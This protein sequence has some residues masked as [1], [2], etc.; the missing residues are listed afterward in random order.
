M[1]SRSI[2]FT[3]NALDH[4]PPPNYPNSIL[5]LSLKR[6]VSPKELNGKVYPI[7]PTTPGI[8]E[9]RCYP[10]NVDGTPPHQLKFNELDSS[11]SD[12]ELRESAFHPLAFEDET[13]CILTSAICHAASDGMGV[14]SV[15][16]IW[17][18]NCRDVQL[19]KVPQMKQPPERGE[20]A[21]KQKAN[22]LQKAINAYV[23]YISP[24]N[25]IALREECMKELGATQVSVNDV[26]CALV[27]RCLL[28][29]RTAARESS[30]AKAQ[31]L[32]PNYLGNFTIINQTLLP[33]P[34]LVAPSRIAGEV[35]PANLM[36]AYVLVKTVRTSL[37]LENLKVD[38]NG[39]MITSL[40]AFPLVEICFGETIFGDCGKPK[41][42]RTLMGAINQTFRYSVILPRKDYR[43]VEVVANL[44]QGEMDILM[45]DE[46]FLKYV[47][48]VA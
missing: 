21:P 42:L 34:D 15:L 7:S 18:D 23:F 45:E 6:G 16:K 27:W 22:G 19:G 17:A 8:L 32:P 25:V 36:D 48:S 10:V 11:E 37:K 28:K 43:G 5:Y 46:E 38:G 14:T 33:L 39:L 41:A 12:E 24:A 30:G 3:L 29:A 31:T 20:Q 13:F 9:I 4:L 44:F 1:E 47:M 40:L 26:I 2:H 35:T